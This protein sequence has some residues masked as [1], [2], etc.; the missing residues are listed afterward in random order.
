MNT[1]NIILIIAF[2]IKMALL[3]FIFQDKLV[4]L[5]SAKNSTLKTISCTESVTEDK[6]TII[7]DNQD[8][9][10]EETQETSE[11]VE[12]TDGETTQEVSISAP[13]KAKTV[14]RRR[15]HSLV[16]LARH[17][18]AFSLLRENAKATDPNVI[19]EVKRILADIENNQSKVFYTGF[20]TNNQLDGLSNQLELSKFE[21]PTNNK[22][23]SPES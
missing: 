9:T 20:K 19:P 6:L 22:F 1:D 18:F 8:S 5:I 11:E 2:G 12:L 10:E 16:K 15:S 23:E 14:K 4:A 21:M 7:M 3:A 13:A 17:F